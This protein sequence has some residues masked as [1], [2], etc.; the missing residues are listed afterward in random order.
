MSNILNGRRKGLER[1]L[2]FELCPKGLN[3]GTTG[4]CRP[5]AL[6]ERNPI[7]TQAVIAA[8]SSLGTLALVIDR[9]VELT[10]N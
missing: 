4:S 3:P 10:F 1:F 7:S 6:E 5:E 8:A 9:I 2:F